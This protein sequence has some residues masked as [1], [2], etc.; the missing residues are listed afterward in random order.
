M[1]AV[2]GNLGSEL[3]GY[4]ML[5]AAVDLGL[6]F[7]LIVAAMTIWLRLSHTPQGRPGGAFGTAVVHAEKTAGRR[8]DY[9]PGG[10]DMPR[11]TPRED[12]EERSQRAS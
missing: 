12:F 11:D 9:S 10:V 2:I 3:G 8:Q 4:G 1:A 7:G 6:T 5:A